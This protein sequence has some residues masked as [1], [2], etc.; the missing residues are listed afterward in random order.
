MRQYQLI[1]EQVKAH[2]TATVIAPAENHLLVSNA[3]H[4]EKY[5]DVGFKLLQSEKEVKLVLK[6][7]SDKKKGTLTFNLVVDDSEIRI[8]DL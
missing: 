2:K 6:T 7:V 5:K 1:W 8:E 3:V 4:K